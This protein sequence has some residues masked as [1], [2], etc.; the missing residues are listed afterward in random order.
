VASV[1]RNE[2]KCAEK[3]IDIVVG[4]P[5]FRSNG[6]SV[7]HNEGTG[8]IR[9]IRGKADSKILG[10]TMVGATVTELV[11]GCRALLGTTERIEDICFAHPTV[12]EVLKEAWED[13]L[14]ISLHVPPSKNEI[15]IPSRRLFFEA[16][17][18]HF[19]VE[20]SR[21]ISSAFDVSCRF[22]P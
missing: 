11:L 3:G 22:Q 16:E 5:P 8:E 14:G 1:G 9:V 10:V 18:F 20:A 19:F 15:Y 13:A 6:R 7:A 4:K 12:S 21:L 17:V 2:R